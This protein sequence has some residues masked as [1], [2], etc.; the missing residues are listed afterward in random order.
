M[1]WA[2]AAGAWRGGAFFHPRSWGGNPLAPDA[3]PS[4]ADPGL[5]ALRC[6][7]QAVLDSAELA[8]ISTDTHGIIRT[9]S[10]GAQRLLGYFAGE[11]IGRATPARFH[12]PEEMCDRAAALTRALGRR[13]EPGFEVFV[14]PVRAGAS[15]A[16]EWTYVCKDGR[17]VPVLLSITALA[18]PRGRV[19]GYLGIAHDLSE[20]YRAQQDLRKLWRAVEQSPETVVITDPRGTIEYVNPKFVEV[21]GYSVAE[22]KGLNPRV[23]KSGVHPPEF[24]RDM[25]QTLTAGGVWHGEL[26]NKKKN[27]E[28]YWEAAAIAPVRDPRGQIA[29]FVAIKQDIT[30][31]RQATVELRAAKEAAEQANR[32]KS[33]FLAT[34]SHELRTPLNGV[35]GMADLLCGTPLD[36]RQR[37]FAQACRGSASALLDLINDILDFSKIEAGKL[38]LDLHEFDLE[39]TVAETL[40][41]LA[42]RAQAK[43]LELICALAPEVCL[44]LRG[45]SGRLRQICINLVNNAVKFTPA[46]HVALRF[47]AD[48]WQNGRVLLRGAVSDTGIG[49]PADRVGRLF[50]SFTQADSSTTRRYGGTGLG[51]AICKSLAQ[52]MGGQIGVESTPGTGS[53][54]WFTAWLDVCACPLAARACFAPPLRHLRVLALDGNA[55]GREAL[56]EH[57]RAW[58]L[59][60]TTAADGASARDHLRRGAA[61]GQP[62]DLL[63]LDQADD[64]GRELTWLES[65]RRACPGPAPKVLLLCRLGQQPDPQ[66]LRRAG[67]DG[68]LNKPAT[69]SVLLGAIADACAPGAGDRSDIL[70]AEAPDPQTSVQPKGVRVLLAEDNQVNQ[71]VAAE[72][73]RRAGYACDLADDGVQAVAAVY[74]QHYD[75]ILMDCQMPGL[76]GFDATRQVRAAQRTGA[77]PPRLPILAL[78]ANAIAGD[79]QRCL[80]AGMDDY[81]AKPFEP[82]ALLAKIAT[83]L[84]SAPAAAPAAVATPPAPAATEPPAPI[85]ARVLLAQ[86]LGDLAVVEKV[87]QTS[88]TQARAL[89]E[90]LA[91]HLADGAARPTAEAAH[92]LKGTAGVLGAHVL[93][94]LA[95]E[96]EALG[97]AGDLDSARRRIE[98]L[99]QEVDRC[100]AY[101]PQLPARLAAAPPA[102]PAR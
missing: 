102:P 76:D 44:R 59:S 54:F 98:L 73:L 5:D 30:R 71:M 46:G 77:V 62:F 27:G 3:G 48:R 61:A 79:R 2:A 89:T 24:Y 4:G 10:V 45:D 55:A 50:Q 72:I 75:L 9:F 92:A 33:D 19:I 36:A 16:V 82:R 52:A 51:L 47:T 8:I 20:R 101:I 21:T 43:G 25:W 13:V 31:Q 81:L 84:G 32:A 38:E 97:R 35:L 94:T 74:R 95:A 40:A 12:C 83:L 80:E 58:G 53:T 70:A 96:I 88:Q 37:Q 1:A 49:I 11:M 99:R 93:R 22:A 18:D 14:A 63:L 86:C 57:V 41:M 34:M 15:A 60:C 68:M 6:V 67:I 23:L 78:T 42:P 28:L 100:L 26:C 17:R 85:D 29:N 56:A 91:Q 65:L 7:Q 39:P 90:R 66:A 64:T 87:L 69:P